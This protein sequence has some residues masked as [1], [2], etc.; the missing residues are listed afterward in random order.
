MGFSAGASRPRKPVQGLPLPPCGKGSGGWV[1]RQAPRNGTSVRNTRIT[2]T[3]T[4]KKEHSMPRCTMTTMPNSP[5]A[6]AQIAVIGFGSQAM[7]TP[8]PAGFGGRARGLYDARLP[9]PGE[10][11]GLRV[12]ARAQAAAEVMSS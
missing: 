5:P 7:L 12:A 3:Y 1:C 10:E 11:G 8:E 6:R 4:H 2:I 9:V